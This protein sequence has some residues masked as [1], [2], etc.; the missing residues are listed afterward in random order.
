[1]ILWNCAW[2]SLSTWPRTRACSMYAAAP[3]RPYRQS[4]RRPIT[5]SFTTSLPRFTAACGANARI[6]AA[7]AGNS[8]SATCGIALSSTLFSA[9]A[10]RVCCL[11]CAL[12]S[13]AWLVSSRIRSGSKFTLVK[14][15]KNARGAQVSI[16]RLMMS[17]WRA[18]SA[19]KETP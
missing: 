12:Y 10:A 6:C 8:N 15:A 17:N 14:V 16:S 4:R 1:M 5:S 19:Q 11:S 18:C 3:F 2:I 13:A 9:A 7:S